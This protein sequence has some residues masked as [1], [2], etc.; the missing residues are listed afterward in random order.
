DDY[1]VVR[2]VRN[3]IGQTTWL[4][5]FMPRMPV[6]RRRWSDVWRRQIRWGSTRLNLPAEVKAL[7]LFEPAIGWLVAGLAGTMALAAAGAGLTA[8]LLAVVAHTLAWFAAEAWFVAGYGMPF[9]RR[10]W[11]AAVLRE[12]LV[13]LLA[14][15]AWRGRHR[16]D[17]RGTD[18]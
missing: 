13:P 12:T 9:G 3:G 10:A 5:N 17:W 16:I 8:L 14:A 4:A 7:V 11:L 6:G 2:A 18:L 1:S 15:Q